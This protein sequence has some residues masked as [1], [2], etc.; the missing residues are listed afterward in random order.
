MRDRALRVLVLEAAAAALLTEVLSPLHL[1]QRTALAIAWPLLAA[2]GVA[3]GWRARRKFSIRPFETA[4]SAAIAAIVVLVAATAWMSPP[5]TFDAM[6]YHLPRI[7]YWAQAGSVAFFPTTYLTQISSPPLSEYL[8]LHTYVLSGGDHFVNLVTVL[9]FAG[10]I[11]AVSAIARS[12]GLDSRGQAIAALL[13]ATLPSAILQASGAK[14]DCLTALWLVC[15]VYFALE[16]DLAFVGLS[17]GLALATKGTAYLFAPPLLAAAWMV[18][19]LQSR[20]QWILAAL[21]LLGGVLLINA[22]Q[23]GRNLRFSGSPLGYDSAFAN[24]QFRWRNAEFGWKATVSNA[25]RNLSEQLGSGNARW[26]QGVYD[27][28][29]A[30]HRWLRIDPHTPGTPLWSVYGPPA[31]TRHEANANNRWHLLLFAVAALYAV[32]AGWRRREFTWLIYVASLAAGF[33]LFCGY[34]QWPPYSARLFV[35]LFIA[36]AP[37][38]AAV[39][40]RVRPAWLAIPVCLFFADTA[41]LPALQNWT[42]PLRGPNNLFSIPRDRAY[43]TDIPADAATSYPEAVGRIAR[44]GCRAV[45]IDI[46]E[47]QLEYPLQAL[48]RERTPAV[49][50]QHVGVA[51]ATPAVCAVVCLECA[52]KPWKLQEYRWLGRPVEIGR[53]VLFGPLEP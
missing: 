53:L 24:G 27:A 41:R 36:A 15:L 17:L 1:L 19:P 45:G 48:L 29:I 3:Y 2:A 38:G 10:C 5:N 40:S 7:V 49:R 31:N 6:A 13:C 18:R 30:V 35:P 33:L 34:L 23:Y 32:F 14:N 20:R 50:F 16:G 28:V 26:N 8:M 51:G 11:V 4:V 47:N 25:L 52:G 21:W 37:L 43:F 22:P 46:G 12:L 42:R 9:A 39:L 44:T